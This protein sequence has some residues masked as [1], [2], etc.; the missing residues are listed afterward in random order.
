VLIEL[1]ADDPE[2]GRRFWEG[3]LGIE[4][5]PRD[6]QQGRGWQGENDGAV[7]GMHERGTGPGDRFALPY[8]T[9]PD[10]AAAIARVGELGGE[11]VHP[12]ERWAICRDSEGTPFGL[13]AA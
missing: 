10:L 9:V 6:S 4:L 8:F 7:V 13:A 5:E 11:I 2:R 3:L 1:P 12:G